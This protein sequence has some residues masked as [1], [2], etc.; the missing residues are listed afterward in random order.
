MRSDKTGHIEWSDNGEF[1]YFRPNP[2]PFD[3]D[4]SGSINRSFYTISA[5]SKLD[6]R[7]SNIPRE[8][9]FIILNSFAIK[10]ATTSS[11][12]EGSQSTV[13]DIFKEEKEKE[14]DREKALDNQEVRNYKEALL[15][16][17]NAVSENR[18]ITEEL[19]LSMHSILLKGVRGSRKQP[20]SYRKGQVWVGDG[21][22]SVETAEFVP[23][24]PVLIQYAM[25]DLLDYMNNSKE[26]PIRKIAVSHYQFETIHPFADGNGRMG[27]L[28][29]ML[30]LY[31]ERIMDNPFLYIS[32]YFNKYR[33]EYIECLT[34]VRTDGDLRKWLEF[35][36]DTLESQTQRSMKLIDSLED[37]RKTLNKIA[38]A[39]KSSE[40]DLISG[41]L[42]GNP[43]I[44]TNDVVEKLGVSAPTARKLLNILV[45]NNALEIVEGKRKGVLYKATEILNMLEE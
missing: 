15:H 16:G 25:D 2:L 31:K 24:P 20:G 17:I 32:E 38:R 18:T 26:D 45:S 41:M 10:E 35:F 27:R 12:I 4:T 6:G 14:T 43:F 29:I 33:D 3:A 19:I 9:R 8:E 22:D 11:A 7:I 13:S 44:T 39:E 34:R 40:L 37:Y 30:M 21:K 36:L 1:C 23:V 28:L 42:I 5:V